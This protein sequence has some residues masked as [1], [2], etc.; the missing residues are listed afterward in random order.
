[1]ALIRKHLMRTLICVA[2]WVAAGVVAFV[3]A[4]IP[5][6]LFGV[7]INQLSLFGF[8]LALGSWSTMPSWWAKCLQNRRT[9]ATRSGK[10]AC[11]V[12]YRPIAPAADDHR[13]RPAFVSAHGSSGS[14]IAPVATLS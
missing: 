10:K 5:M 9:P 11:S 7:T 3:G 14:F 6:L 2:A 4:F 8:I 1:V 12:I 13:L